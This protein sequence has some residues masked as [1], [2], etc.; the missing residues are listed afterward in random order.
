LRELATSVF[1]PHA[2]CHHYYNWMMCKYREGTSGAQSLKPFLY[3]VRPLLAIRWLEQGRGLVPAALATV[4]DGALD[5]Q[6]AEQAGVKRAIE[7]L[8]SYRKEG[9]EP[10][11]LTHMKLVQAFTRR[12]IERLRDRDF[13]MEMGRAASVDELDRLLY[14]VL[15]ESMDPQDIAPH[16]RE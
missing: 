3:V 14:S 9:R 4:L 6:D 12:E 2:C 8:V 5:G 16:S 10:A 15:T 1:S 11:G 13:P 7:Q